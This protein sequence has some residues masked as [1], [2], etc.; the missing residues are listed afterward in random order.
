MKFKKL[1]KYLFWLF[2][3]LVISGLIVSPILENQVNIDDFRE[4][5]NQLGILAPI[6]FIVILA[7]GTIFIPSTPFMLISGIL[8][9][10]AH[11]LVFTMI[12]GLMSSLITFYIS[13]M[14]GRSWVESILNSKYLESI[15]KYNHRLE[16][17]GVADLVILRI[18][19][20]MPFNVL[21]ILMGL[22]RISLTN[23]ILGTF[24]GLLPSNTITV[25]L[26]T[27]LLEVL[28]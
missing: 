12:G 24:V 14:M 22:S 26:G 6:V 15:K 3:C 5:I 23:Y 1:Q 17:S 11:G 8:F 25:Y 18:L 20:I 9:G 28:S 2:I 19:P 4:Y 10:F 21:N 16:N 13:R 7:I 27:L